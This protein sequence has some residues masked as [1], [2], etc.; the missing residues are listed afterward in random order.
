MRD[1]FN[2]NEMDVFGKKRNSFLPA[3]RTGFS[4]DLDQIMG[5]LRKNR[6]EF[7]KMN[8]RQNQALQKNGFNNN[9]ALRLVSHFLPKRIKEKVEKQTSPLRT[10]GRELV[11]LIERVQIT[12][13]DLAKVAFLKNEEIEISRRELEEIKNNKQKWDVVAIR[14]YFFNEVGLPLQE[15]S[16]IKWMSDRELEL[17]PAKKKEIKRKELLQ[18]LENNVNAGGG[19]IRLLGQVAGGGIELLEKSTVQYWCLLQIIEPVEIL[20]DS[21][22]TFGSLNLGACQAKQIAKEYFARAVESIELSIE[23][24]KIL[25][26]H[27]IYGPDMI[28]D[29]DESTRR[30][31]QK[32]D[33]IHNTEGKI[34]GKLNDF[35]LPELPSPSSKK[36]VEAKGRRKKR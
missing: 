21:A 2:K 23:A 29:L 28:E 33:A 9:R 26:D 22:R 10:I 6:D 14:G 25:K 8:A 1:V 17:L 34:H 5:R 20:K 18:I 4:R 13:T 15:G 24:V 11:G 16:P 3:S 30:L 27:L 19:L 35:A 7:K 31:E 36:D 32:V 12:L